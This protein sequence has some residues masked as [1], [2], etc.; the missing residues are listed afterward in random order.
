MKTGD[1]VYTPRF[2]NV[3]IKEVFGDTGTARAAGYIEPTHY[4]KDGWT[5]FGKT[6]SCP[7]PGWCEMAFAAVKE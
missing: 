5:V 1:N 3:T 4:H 2:C 6:V 7:R